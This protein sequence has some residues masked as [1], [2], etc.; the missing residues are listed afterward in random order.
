MA[1]YGGVSDDYTGF[2]HWWDWVTDRPAFFDSIE[3]LHVLPLMCDILFLLALTY[4]LKDAYN[5][6]QYSQL[7]SK[8]LRV[9]ILVNLY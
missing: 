7:P 8:W 1:I 3:R 2:C 9:T 5:I 4:I 6:T